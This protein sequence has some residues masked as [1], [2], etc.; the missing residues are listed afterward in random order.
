MDADTAIDAMPESEDVYPSA[1]SASFLGD[2]DPVL[3]TAHK[4]AGFLLSTGLPPTRAVKL[5]RRRL[6]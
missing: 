1:T 6:R 4:S 5:R 3:N 2:D